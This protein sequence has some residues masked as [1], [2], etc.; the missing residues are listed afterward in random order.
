MVVIEVLG[1]VI[2][3]KVAYQV[4]STYRTCPYVFEYKGGFYIWD[5]HYWKMKEWIKNNEK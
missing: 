1:V 2:K 4:D 3:E 5:K